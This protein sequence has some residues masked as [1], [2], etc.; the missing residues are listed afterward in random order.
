MWT[1]IPRIQMIILQPQILTLLSLSIVFCF[2]NAI[3][4]NIVISR[5][6]SIVVWIYGQGCSCSFHEEHICLGSCTSCWLFDCL[7]RYIWVECTIEGHRW[8]CSN[9]FEKCPYVCCCSRCRPA[10]GGRPQVDISNSCLET[11]LSESALFFA[12][13]F[14]AFLLE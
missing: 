9:C 7:K 3:A 1:S 2:V 5:I 4:T 12:S 10:V 13:S 14:N 6:V 11:D 8:C